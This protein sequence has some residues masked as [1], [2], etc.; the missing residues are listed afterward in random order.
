MQNAIRE[1]SDAELVEFLGPIIA[2]LGLSGAEEAASMY[3]EL[4][5]DARFGYYDRERIVGTAALLDFEA[6]VPGGAFVPLAGLTLVA[7][8]PTHR[9]KGVLRELMARS[10]GE[11]RARGKS[12]SALFASEGAIYGRFGYGLAS[13][14]LNL[15]V[16]NPRQLLPQRPLGADA[17]FRLLSVSEAEA[18]FPKIWE[19]ARPKY[20]GMLSRTPAWWHYRRV[21]EPEWRRRGKP[22][23]QN[24]LLEVRGEP[25]GYAIYRQG[26]GFEQGISTAELEVLEALALTDDATFSIWRY[27]FDLDLVARLKVQGLP[28]DH[29]IVHLVTEPA[30]LRPRLVPALYVRLVD[31][32]AALARRKLGHGKSVVLGIRDATCPWNEGHFRVSS[33]GAKRTSDAADLELDVAEL[34]SVYLGGFSLRELAS[35]GRVRELTPE[36]VERADEL[37]VKTRAPFC[38]DMF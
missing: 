1:V 24:V 6:T 38:P 2:A 35:A 29:P 16:R 37:F 32:E 28:L 10:F 33:E 5:H 22:A 31:V 18:A 12:I 3:R 34:G 27:L 8:R 7:V 23:A 20:P 36:S 9:R 21:G 26:G 17:S 15:D 14:W 13:W 30:R 11:A 19:A 4:P 25:V